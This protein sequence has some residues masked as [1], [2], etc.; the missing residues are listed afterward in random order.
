[1]PPRE[2]FAAAG[3]AGSAPDPVPPATAGRGRQGPRSC[4]VEAA[5]CVVLVPDRCLDEHV[6]HSVASPGWCLHPGKELLGPDAVP[7]AVSRH[8]EP[9]RPRL[10]QADPTVRPTTGRPP[11]EP[12][13]LAADAAG[14]PTCAGNHRLHRP[15]VR[16]IVFWL[17][18]CR[19]DL[20]S[21]A[22][23]NRPAR[24]SPGQQRRCRPADSPPA[25]CSGTEV[26][27]RT[28][29]GMISDG[30]RPGRGPAPPPR[31]RAIPPAAC[32]WSGAPPWHRSPT[33]P[34]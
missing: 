27:P 9:P 11:N 22:E 20:A 15:P 17:G 12:F 13:V 2:E 33:G 23:G 7:A 28:S 6:R 24:Q 21:D 3:W 4:S 1:M 25:G 10:V 16:E 31:R 26:G 34:R 8:P 14:L 32:G 19:D 30:G 18:E 5:V 29:G